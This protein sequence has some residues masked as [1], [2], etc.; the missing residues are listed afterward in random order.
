MKT[1]Q[2][3][4]QNQI[5]SLFE[6]ESVQFAAIFGSRA[7]EN[8]Q[9]TSDFDLLI[10]FLPTKKY[11]LSDLVFLK[12]EMEKNIGAEV[13]LVTT[14]GLNSKMAREI[15]ESSRVIYDRRKR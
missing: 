6:R 5:N 1:I 10:E 15:K 3:P 14:R 8:A 11:S 7:K 2:I 13:D 4:N 9:K 12:R